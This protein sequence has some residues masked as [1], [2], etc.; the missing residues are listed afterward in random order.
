MA[1][2]AEPIRYGVDV[3]KETLDI[4]QSNT[5]T[6]VQLTNKCSAIKSWL[7]T[8]PHGSAIALEAT[9]NYHHE[10]VYLAHEHGFT[11]YL[12]DGYRLSK[13]R[14]GVGVR[15]KTDAQDA[16][17]ILRFMT[18]EQEA[19]TPWVPPPKTFYRIQNL[20]RRRAALVKAQVALRQSL[21]GL[22][23]LKVLSQ[24][25]DT[26]LTHLTEQLT[27]KLKCLFKEVGWWKHAQR[28]QQIE[29]I[30]ELRAWHW[31]TCFTGGAL[32][33]LTRLLRIWGWT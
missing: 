8:L 18:H 4:A 12:L 22:P 16:Q 31:R 29:G 7:N 20:L 19:L 24:Q 28:C 30:G 33:M 25:L 9:G 1:K 23:E 3:S 5:S 15:A 13:Y 2:L 17:L 32:I 14:E 10:L 11:L 26:R 6:S 27:Q 21:S